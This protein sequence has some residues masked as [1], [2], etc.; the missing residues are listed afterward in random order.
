METISKSH[1]K[2]NYW[3]GNSV[4]IKGS[5]FANYESFLDFHQSFFENIWKI[6]N[7]FSCY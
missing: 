7:S 4:S 3:L 2:W 6:A 1:F 5:Q